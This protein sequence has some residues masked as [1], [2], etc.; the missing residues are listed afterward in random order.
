M[1]EKNFINNLIIERLPGGDNNSDG[2]SECHEYIIIYARNIESIK[3]PIINN[4][5]FTNTQISK[6]S[7]EDEK[8]KYQ[9]RSLNKDGEGSTP[10]ESPGLEFDILISRNSKKIIGVGGECESDNKNGEKYRCDF[11][12]TDINT[13]TGVMIKSKRSDFEKVN[14]DYKSI[15]PE[16]SEGNRKRWTW[17]RAT[18][19]KE[20][21]K[22]EPQDIHVV[23]MAG[24]LTIRRKSRLDK[25]TGT[26]PKTIWHDY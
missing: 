4:I 1:E 12:Y 13:N 24:E 7:K 22:M 6:Y 10:S 14:P 5:S 23:E 11:V 16:N 26:K 21:K 2:F 25:D 18:I 20:I 17:A 15:M 8:S 19:L 3:K 9:N